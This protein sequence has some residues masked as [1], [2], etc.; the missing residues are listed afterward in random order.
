MTNWPDVP[1]VCFGK[2]GP[3]HLITNVDWVRQSTEI[4]TRAYV[5]GYRRAAEALFAHTT[6]VQRMS[7]EYM[8]WPLAFLWRHHVELALKDIIATGRQI[9]N[10]DEG[11]S[12][13]RIHR[14]RELWDTAKPHIVMYGDPNAPELANVAGNIDEFESVD[15]SSTSFRYAPEGVGG[16]RKL[17]GTVNLTALHE[18][19][20]AISNFLDAVHECQQREIEALQS[21]AD[22]RS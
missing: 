8:L 7:P 9:K 4:A 6:T 12:F 14:L 11:R 10:G 16:L 3:G 21:A 1:R 5:E 17:P 19:M 20:V 18:A 22:Y 13:P 2:D 15:E